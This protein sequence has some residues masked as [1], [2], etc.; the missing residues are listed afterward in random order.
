MV[1]WPIAHAVGLRAPGSSQK[2]A[3]S[4]DRRSRLR[5]LGPRVTLGPGPP[6]RGDTHGHRHVGDALMASRARDPH[7]L[8]VFVGALLAAVVGVVAIAE[9][10]RWWVLAAAFAAVILLMVAIVLDVSAA[11]DAGSRSGLARPSRR[12]P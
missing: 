10:H 4:A 2:R 7:L 3:F 9:T 12:K 5:V 8:A 1:P 6:P 11:V